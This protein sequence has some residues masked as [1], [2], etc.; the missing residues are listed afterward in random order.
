MCSWFNAHPDVIDIFPTN[1]GLTIDQIKSQK[2][3]YLKKHGTHVFKAI[4]AIA[5]ALNDETKLTQLLEQKTTVH[6]PHK[7]KISEASFKVSY[8]Y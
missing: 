5:Q 3:D 8:I 2:M 6:S 1:E 7:P 4:A